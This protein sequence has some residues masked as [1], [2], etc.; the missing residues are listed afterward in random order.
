MVF[1]PA[2]VSLEARLTT[3][4]IEADKFRKVRR[5]LSDADARLREADE[6]Q[7]Q[8]EVKLKLAKKRMRRD[9]TAS[10]GGLEA[11]RKVCC[12]RRVQTMM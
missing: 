5:D 11:K 8:V 10:P 2:D 12:D 6:D 9:P 3:A 7:A 1:L 4:V